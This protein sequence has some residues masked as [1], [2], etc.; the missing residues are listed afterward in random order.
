V[1]L[2]EI[3]GTKAMYQL[4]SQNFFGGAKIMGRYTHKIAINN[5]RL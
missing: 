2:E 1:L 5:Q 3:K 4:K